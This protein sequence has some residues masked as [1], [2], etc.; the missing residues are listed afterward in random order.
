MKPKRIISF[1]L[2]ICLVAGLMP[3]VAFATGSNKAIMRGT[4]HLQGAQ[5]DNIY[6]GNYFQSNKNTKEPVKWRVLSNSHGKLFLLSDQNLDVKP[7]NSSYTSITWEKSTIRSWLNGYEASKNNSGTDYS[8]NN[9]IDAAF[10]SDEKVAIAD[11]YVYNKTQSNETSNPNPF[12][13]TSGGNNTTDQI[14]LLSIEEANNNN[15]FPN[16]NDS[17][18]STNTA[19]VASC[20][21][22]SGVGAADYWWLRSPGYF[23]II[24][25]YVKDGGGVFYTGGSV[26]DTGIAVRPAF[27]LNLN[28]VLFTSAAVGGKSSGA[29]GADVLQPVSEYAGNEWKLTLLDGN[30]SFT[31]STSSATTQV[32]GYSNWTV[33]VEYSSAQTGSN[34]YV[35]AMIVDGSGSVLYYGRVAQNRVS[36]TAN[37]TIP[38]GLTPG[39]YTL[40]VFSEQYN[41]DKKTDYASAFADID[42][43]VHGWS[44]TWNSDDTYHWHDCTAAGC[45]ITDNSQ[46]DGY[47]EHIF[48]NWATNNDGTHTQTCSTCGAEKTE[49]CTYGEDG[50]CTVCGYAQPSYTI[51][52]GPETLNFG[53]A[54]EGYT[55]PAAQTVTITNTGNQ[56]VTVDLPTSADYTITA[57]TGFEN[58]AASIAANGTAAFTVQP[59][60]GLAPGRHSE[61]LTITGSGNAGAQVSLSFTVNAVYTLTVELNGGSGSTTGGQY[62]AGEVVNIDAGSRSSY[63]FTGWTTS[64]GGSFADASSASTTFTMPAADTTIT[65]NW[66]YDSP[67]IPPTKPDGPSTGSSD[68]WEDIREEIA[69]ADKGDTSPST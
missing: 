20:S 45:P 54:T 37:I 29:V 2:A 56:L 64:T 69:D 49:S 27:N 46:K 52:A 21:G 47:G 25:A 61:T 53:S 30:R 1:L 33:D 41:G 7:Y 19:Y 59:K 15:Y 35:S 50:R 44:D 63:R 65:A 39:S 11:T 55:A 5:A 23:D 51:S 62:P 28:S 26:V 17:R 57:G 66:Q 67:Y 4:E 36:G 8:S 48:G 10:S 13:N 34:E 43:H 40:K 58:G 3:T 6:F 68:G 9:F 18:K 16:G 31:A 60:T 14:F 42:L 22:M 12:Y 38:S 32:Q 24:A